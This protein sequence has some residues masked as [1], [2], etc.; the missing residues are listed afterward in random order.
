MLFDEERAKKKLRTEV[1][2]RVASGQPAV[3]MISAVRKLN[4]VQEGEIMSPSQELRSLKDRV[5][6]VVGSSAYNWVE[7]SLWSKMIGKQ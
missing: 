2:R 5:S 4:E 3:E 7:P 6:S 1:D